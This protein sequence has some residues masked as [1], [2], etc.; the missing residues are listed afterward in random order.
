MWDLGRVILWGF[1]L[2]LH[3]HICNMKPKVL[4]LPLWYHEYVSN[5][6]FVKTLLNIKNA[7]I[8]MIKKK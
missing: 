5:L 4:F 3:A 6:F 8:L 1:A 2:F 7:F